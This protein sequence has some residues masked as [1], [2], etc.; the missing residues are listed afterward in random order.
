MCFCFNT[1][2]ISNPFPAF[3]GTLVPTGSNGKSRDPRHL[4]TNLPHQSR[5]VLNYPAPTTER[6]V[7]L[8]AGRSTRVAPR[9]GRSQIFFILTCAQYGWFYG[10]SKVGVTVAV[11]DKDAPAWIITHV[12][13]MQAFNVTAGKQQQGCVAWDGLDENFW[14]VTTLP[15]P[16]H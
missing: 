13:Y 1:A 8:H 6:W 12:S 9:G 15:S 4:H 2:L 11:V 5:Y 16:H 3:S 7:A 14:S 10:I